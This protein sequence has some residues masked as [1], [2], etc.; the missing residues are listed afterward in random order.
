MPRWFTYI[1][2]CSDNSYYA[3]STTDLDRRLAEHQAGRGGA[4]T[5]ARRPV[6]L[7]WSQGCRDRSS[8]QRREARIKAMPRAE[9]AAC[10]RSRRRL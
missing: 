3:G 4:Y 5:R 9:K 1:L 6:R 2:H 10:V 8:A 7:V